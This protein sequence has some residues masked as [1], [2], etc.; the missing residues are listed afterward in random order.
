MKDTE[1]RKWGQTLLLLFLCA[2]LLLACGEI[3]VRIWYPVRYQEQVRYVSGLYSVPPALVL[4]VIRSESGF[5]PRAVSGVGAMG[6]MQ[7][8]PQT[9]AEVSEKVLNGEGDP[10]CVEDNLRC[11]VAYLRLMLSRYSVL[12]TALAAYNAGPGTVDGWLADRSLSPDGK[13]LAEI[14][15]PE[16]EEYVARVMA[17]YTEYSRL[18]GE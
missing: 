18:L 17:A 13:T 8:M 11:G 7:L 4:A 9:F 14:P 6:L 12:G 5:D 2:L 10:F 16:T 15:Y 1:K 3:G